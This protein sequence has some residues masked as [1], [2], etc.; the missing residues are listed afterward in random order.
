MKVRIGLFIDFVLLKAY[1]EYSVEKKIGRGAAA[2][3]PFI[4]RWVFSVEL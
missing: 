3:R 1:P 4:H 2:L